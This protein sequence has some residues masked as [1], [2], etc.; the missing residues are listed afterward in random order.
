[1]T[2]V[3]IV[4]DEA[5]VRKLMGA[6][7]QAEGATTTE[8]DGAEQALALVE[9]EG[10]P[11]V[12]LCD[13]QLPGRDGLWLAEQLR[14]SCPDTAVVMTTGVHEFDAAVRSLET[15]AVAYL[16]KPFTRR[17]FSEALNRADV[18]HRSRRALAEMHK[19]LE[20]R[21]VQIKEEIDLNASSSLDAMLAMLQTRN[22]GV[23]EQAHRVASLAVKLAMALQIGKPD[24]IDIERA[25]LL[26]DIGKLSVPDDLLTRAHTA[27]SDADRTRLNFYALQGHVI[28]RNVPF[29]AG[30]THIAVAAYERY[31]GKGFPRSLRGDQIPIGA[32]IIAVAR[33]YDELVWPDVHGPVRA[34]QALDTLLRERASEFDQVV[35]DALK[36]LQPWTDAA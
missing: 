20:R 12:A 9:A 36:M 14:V 13:V 5:P 31:D 33:A 26:H 21:R 17:Q 15:G 1:M 3:L 25:A 30:A 27:L 32:R 16:A 4:D 28:L 2:R 8:A 18:A 7:V 35:L 34:G 19:E 6:W 24:V 29:L 22:A 23:L 11:A 10:P